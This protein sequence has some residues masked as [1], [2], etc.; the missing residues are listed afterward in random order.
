M[1]KREHV[2]LPDMNKAISVHL[3]FAILRTPDHWLLGFLEEKREDDSNMSPVLAK[4][5]TSGRV[6]FYDTQEVKYPVIVQSG[7]DRTD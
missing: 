1:E 7:L 2:H 5:D 3:R 6:T 4:L